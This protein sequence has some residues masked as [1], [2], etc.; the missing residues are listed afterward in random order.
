LTSDLDSRTSTR[1]WPGEDTRFS[2]AAFRLGSVTKL[3]SWSQATAAQ[4]FQARPTGL[5]L[6]SRRTR[7]TTS[8]RQRP[9]DLKV[10]QQSKALVSFNDELRKGNAQRRVAEEALR[11]AEARL[12]CG[13]SC[14]RRRAREELGVRWIAKTLCPV[15]PSVR[16]CICRC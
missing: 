9:R 4:A 11:L 6:T 13:P 8:N 15:S 12:A 7:R 1:P 3:V 10:D 16:S 14:S 2:V 5:S